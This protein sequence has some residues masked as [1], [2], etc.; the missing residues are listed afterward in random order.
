MARAEENDGNNI[1]II[2]QGTTITGEIQVN[3]DLRLAGKLKGKLTCARDLVLDKTGLVEGDVEV[4]S[5]TLCGTV[6]GN[7]KVSGRLTLEKESLLEGDI[8]TKEL[9]INQGATFRGKCQMGAPTS[10]KPEAKSL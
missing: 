5:A 1:T 6:K 3:N 4:A 8:D 9:V 7:V 10:A 2:S